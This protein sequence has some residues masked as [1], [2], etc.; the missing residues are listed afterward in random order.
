MSCFALLLEAGLVDRVALALVFRRRTPGEVGL[1]GVVAVV[2]A[3]DVAAVVHEAEGFGFGAAAIV[4]DA[5]HRNFQVRVGAHRVGAQGL[6]R[7]LHVDLADLGR[8]S[9]SNQRSQKREKEHVV[10]LLPNV[11]H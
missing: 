1:V 3:A 7:K 6:H 9:A 10:F 8:L 5:E 2:H 11:T 4:A